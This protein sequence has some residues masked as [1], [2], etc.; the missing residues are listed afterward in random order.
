MFV[1]FFPNPRLFF[2]SAAIWGLIAV[3]AWFFFFK[4]F[5]ANI[6]LPRAAEDAPD[7]WC[8][9]ISLA[10]IYLVLH[11]LFRIYH[12]FCCFLVAG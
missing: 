2:S 5:G 3:L 11:L 1:S 4:D 8:F 7:Y 6:G 9:E 12:G 10:T